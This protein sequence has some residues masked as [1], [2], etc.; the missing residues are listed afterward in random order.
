MGARLEVERWPTRLDVLKVVKSA[1]RPYSIYIG[2]QLL[3]DHYGTRFPPAGAR[4]PTNA[5]IR[6]RLLGLVSRD[7]LVCCG[8]VGGSYG[9]RWEITAKGAA[10]LEAVP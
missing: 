6:N 4:R 2:D 9:Y 3:S 5:V 10:A 1:C 7:L 8:H